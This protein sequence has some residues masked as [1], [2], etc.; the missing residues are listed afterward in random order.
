MNKKWDYFCQIVDQHINDKEEYVQNIFEQMF[1]ELFGYS[2]LF[3]EIDSHRVLRIGS[4]D[5]VIPDIIIRKP[6][7]NK[8]LFIVELKQLSSRFDIKY[9]AQLLSY[10]RLLSLNIGILI[11]D[12]IYVYY[13]ENDNPVSRAIS[14]SKENKN[15]ESFID[16]FSKGGF[17]EDKVKDFVLQGKAFEKNVQKIREELKELDIKEVV[18]LYFL[19]NFEEAE[20]DEA[21][22]N[23][24]I[25]VSDIEKPYIIIDKPGIPPIP[26]HPPVPPVGRETIQKWVQR[27]FKYLINKDILSE[28]E[29]ELLH[30]TDY[31]KRTFGIA[32]AMLVDTPKDT[33]FANHSRYWQT[34][35]GKWYICSQWWVQKDMEYDANIRAWLHKVLPDYIDCGLDRMY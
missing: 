1:A 15:G 30:N 7:E 4:S 19:S 17:S 35:I 22:K 33:I 20:I 32:Y 13:L 27:I 29:I 5:R 12:K 18:K 23:K 10:M 16:I 9:E 2:R 6:S 24:K 34:P 25:L 8:D 3:G 21:L 31:S 28:Q 11:C 26:T 14:V